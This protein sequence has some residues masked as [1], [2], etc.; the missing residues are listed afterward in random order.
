MPRTAPEVAQPSK[1]QPSEEALPESSPWERAAKKV[2]TFGLDAQLLLDEAAAILDVSPSSFER[3]MIPCTPWS[4]RGRRWRY[5][6][7]VDR[8]RDL[9][10]RKAGS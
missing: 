1:R 8:G 10:R 4:A 7:I 3:L 5:G 6:A 2:A 9:E